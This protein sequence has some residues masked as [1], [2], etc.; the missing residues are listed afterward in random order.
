MPEL[1]TAM[2]EEA[3]EVVDIY[4]RAIFV[5]LAM[6]RT[7]FFYEVNKRL[8]RFMMNGL[9]LMQVIRPSIFRPDINWNVTP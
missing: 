9:L 6:A 2:K 5:F 4:A 1:F 8:G 3:E 7:Q